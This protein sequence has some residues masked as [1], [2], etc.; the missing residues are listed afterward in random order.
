MGNFFKYNLIAFLLP[1]L[2]FPFTFLILSSTPMFLLKENL[3]A[4][5]VL[6]SFGAVLS[7]YVFFAINTFF[8]IKNKKF[9]KKYLI[10]LI[11]FSIYTYLGYKVMEKLAS[12][13]SN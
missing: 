9:E 13:F 4:G 2:L 1:L 8:V 11:F 5:L 10:L 3:T 6:I 7:A 12:G